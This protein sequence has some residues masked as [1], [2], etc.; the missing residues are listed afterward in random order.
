LV[1]EDEPL[2]AELA[3]ILLEDIGFTVDVAEDG[4]AALECAGKFAYPLILMDVQMPRMN[5]L[6]A[7]RA[8]RL[9]PAHARTPIIACTGN[10]FTEVR[11]RCMEA[12]MT[13]FITKPTLPDVLYAAILDALE[14]ALF[15]HTAGSVGAGR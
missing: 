7:T 10:A 6:D 3:L 14:R 15:G 5:G 13:G 4:Q 1:A 8:I 9:L 12:G 11:V 2:N